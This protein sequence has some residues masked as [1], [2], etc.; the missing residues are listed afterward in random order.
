MELPAPEHQSPVYSHVPADW[1]GMWLRGRTRA[2]FHAV[3][4]DVGRT[5]SWALQ[6][7][8]CRAKYI[9]RAAKNSRVG[10]TEG[11]NWGEI[12]VW[13]GYVPPITPKCKWGIEASIYLYLHKLHVHFANILYSGWP[14]EML[15][16]STVDVLKRDR[17]SAPLRSAPLHS[18]I[19]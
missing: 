3:K 2:R 18:S 16:C 5:P 1:W 11:W 10:V 15:K 17:R 6:Q 8:R 19:L 4:T 12:H 9:I 14:S 7:V 13:G